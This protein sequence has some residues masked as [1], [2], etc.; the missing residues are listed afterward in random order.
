MPLDL[1]WQLSLS[2]A[3]PE[4]RELTALFSF[5]DTRTY[6]IGLTFTPDEGV[7]LDARRISGRLRT[8]EWVHPVASVERGELP[9]GLV[10]HWVAGRFSFLGP[11]DLRRVPV[12]GIDSLG[13]RFENDAVTV[14]LDLGLWSTR[15]EEFEDETGFARVATEVDGRRAERVSFQGAEGLAIPSVDGTN[16]FSM[17]VRLRE[18]EESGG[19]VDAGAMLASV[20]FPEP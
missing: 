10:E 13:A 16:R 14:H 20:R 2:S 19:P 7:E 3:N 6:R 12:R 1:E 5:S 15:F 8:F 4:D 17:L 11:P 18:S 9:P